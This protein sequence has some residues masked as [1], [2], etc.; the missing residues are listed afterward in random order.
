M[1][2]DVVIRSARPAD[3]PAVAAAYEW[4]FVPPGQRP[5]HWDEANAV[6]ALHQV[7]SSDRSDVLIAD[8]QGNPVGFCT[9]YLD[10]LSVRFGQRSWI[11]DLAVHPHRRSQN[12]GGRLLTA[13]EDWARRHGATHIELDSS[14]DRTRAHRFYE[15]RKPTSRSQCFSWTL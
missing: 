9:V 11:E 15:S 14:N 2:H 4:L 7:S 3:M 12:I 1:E 13:A 5:P 6:R 8:A 10:I